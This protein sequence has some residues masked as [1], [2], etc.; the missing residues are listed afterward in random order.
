M[1]NFWVGK[2]LFIRFKV[3]NDQRQPGYFDT[4]PAPA[5]W[6]GVLRISSDRDDRMGA[7]M[8]T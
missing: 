8:E 3:I 5:A 1:K 6:G 2:F 4:H 7:K